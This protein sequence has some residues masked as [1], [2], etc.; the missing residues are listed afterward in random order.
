MIQ[1]TASATDSEDGTLPNSAYSWLIVLHHCYTLTNC[2]THDLTG[3]IGP[4][5][6]LIAP[7]HGYPSYLDIEVTVTDS[8]GMAVTKTV[9]LYPKTV[10]LTFVTNPPGLQVYDGDDG[11][12]ETTPITPAGDHRLNRVGQRADA[13]GPERDWIRL[14]ELVRWRSPEP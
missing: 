6:Q 14:L 12:N 7:D 1:M 9:L 8:D 13:A 5:G 11:P 3:F 2:H 4:S 10:N